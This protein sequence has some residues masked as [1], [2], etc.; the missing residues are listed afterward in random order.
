[1]AGHYNLRYYVLKKHPTVVMSRYI[2]QIMNTLQPSLNDAIFFK[3]KKN[4]GL[5]GQG[6]SE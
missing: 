1:M 2:K 4:Y 3:K 6:R 5:L